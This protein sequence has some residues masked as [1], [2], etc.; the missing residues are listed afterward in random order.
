V[1]CGQAVIPTDG[2]ADRESQQDLGLILHRQPWSLPGQRSQ[3]AGPSPVATMVSSN[4]TAMACDTACAAA[5]SMSGH[6]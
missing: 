4:K 6:G 2:Q 1:G 5:V 3:R